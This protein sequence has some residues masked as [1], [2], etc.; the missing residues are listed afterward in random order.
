MPAT[1]LRS[2]PHFPPP[3]FPSKLFP[4]D[5]MGNDLEG[6]ILNGGQ[7]MVRRCSRYDHILEMAMV[8][9]INGED[10]VGIGRD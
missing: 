1:F 4:S 9:V 6:S 5:A 2:E 3:L 10:E 7:W 8:G